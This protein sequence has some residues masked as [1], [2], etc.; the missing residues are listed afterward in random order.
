ME[1]KKEKKERRTA[2][3]K[4][5]RT[6]LIVLAATVSVCAYIIFLLFVYVFSKNYIP[7]RENS[8]PDFF[9]DT[10][11]SRYL[12]NREAEVPSRRAESNVLSLSP[13]TDR[14]ASVGETVRVE[15]AVKPG[16]EP[17][18]FF[19]A[20][21]VELKQNGSGN[22]EEGTLFQGE[23]AVP[24]DAQGGVFGA[25]EF[26]VEKDGVTE[27]ITAAV[28][29]DPVKAAKDVAEPI[30]PE[31][32]E[33]GTYPMVELLG[34]A[35]TYDGREEDNKNTALSNYP[36]G[37]TDY[38]C[39]ENRY[40]DAEGNRFTFLLLGSGRRI[41]IK[42]VTDTGDHSVQ[43][44]RFD[45][46]EPKKNLLTR[47]RTHVTPSETEIRLQSGWKVPVEVRLRP[48]L[49]VSGYQERPY[50][51]DRFSAHYLDI[52]F[53]HTKLPREAVPVENS[54]LFASSEWLEDETGAAVLRLYMKKTSEFSGY[55]LSYTPEGEL[56]ITFG[57]TP[58]LEPA[59]NPYGYSLEGVR[60]AVDAG[61][62]GGAPGAVGKLNGEEVL[63][64]EHTRRISDQ[65]IKSLKGLGA[66]VLDVRSGDSRMNQN[67]RLKKAREFSPHL[68]LSIHLNSG[69][70]GKTGAEGYYYH[71][72]SQPLA[73]RLYRALEAAYP[74]AMGYRS[75][76][77][78]MR[79]RYYPFAVTRVSEYPAVLMELGYM[80][81]PKELEKLCDPDAQQ[82]L[83]EALTQGIV[84]YL[85]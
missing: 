49:Y 29:R 9:S 1:I 31:K 6:L 63:E 74:D 15:I 2:A 65:L 24:E 78:E 77:R 28:L 85:K 33:D 51:V 50:N 70:D 17:K 69:G 80:D 81:N 45:A 19:Q 34:E 12:E 53:H 42:A 43:V 84:D 61:H 48:Q 71:P 39:G 22:S 40:T 56:R 27:R 55:E 18:C 82:M 30:L 66:E 79:I 3:F 57:H 64:K 83:A 4:K 8:R 11:L 5:I 72:F 44:R 16:A 60:I 46:P 58:Y 67:Q 36:A 14:I 59:D 37:T 35:E 54:P 10:A 23:F 21:V 26:L 68:F 52:R 7:P 62:G 20:L 41:C 76:E 73:E 13:K 47:G 38:I 25:I 75:P 32:N